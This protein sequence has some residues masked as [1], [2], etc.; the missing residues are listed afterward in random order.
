VS[1]AAL[2]LQPLPP[3]NRSAPR[4]STG[5]PS[6]STDY[7]GI[8]MPSNKRTMLEGRLRRRMRATAWT[9]STT[10]AATCSTRTAGRRDDP[11][12]RRGDHQQDRVLPRAGA[13][14]LHGKDGA[15][16]AGQ[17][18]PAADQGLERGLL[19][20]RRALHHGH[21]AG[22]VL[23]EQ[24]GLD[25]SIL[26]TD[27]CTE[28][29]EQA[30]AGRFSESMIQPVSAASPALRDEGQG[31]LAGEVRIAPNL[32]AKVAFGAPEPDGRELSGRSRWTS[33][34]AATS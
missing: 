13:L 9:A 24:R 14:H 16:A 5:W 11:P 27:I 15:A 30:I 23:R 33:S 26:A 6:S 8:K 31:P 1:Q 29:L 4:T 19:D 21:G 7:S 28:V 2:A 32:R 17:G 12:D 18:R 20:R 3:A 10:T 34:S 22:R 25:Y